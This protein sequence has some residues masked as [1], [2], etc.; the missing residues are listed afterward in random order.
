MRDKSK[1]VFKKGDLV[2]YTGNQTELFK[3]DMP[4]KVA[5][6]V[7]KSINYIDL[8]VYINP[9]RIVYVDSKDFISQKEWE[10]VSFDYISEEEYDNDN[11][12]KKKKNDFM[13]GD[14]VYYD[15]DPNDKIKRHIAFRLWAGRNNTFDV[16]TP[17]ENKNHGVDK[18]EW[19][20]LPA[21][22]VN[23]NFIHEEEYKKKYP[24]GSPK[25]SEHQQAAV[26]NYD[27]FIK[28]FK[29]GDTI[30]YVGDR[31]SRFKKDTP[32]KVQFYN[33][34]TKVLKIDGDIYPSDDFIKEEEYE[35]LKLLND[36]N[37]VESGGRKKKN[38]MEIKM[39]L[40]RDTKSGKLIWFRPYEI[41]DEWFRTKIKLD[42]PPGAYLRVDLKRERDQWE[43]LIYYHRNSKDKKADDNSLLIQNLV[44]SKIITA[45]AKR[46]DELIFMKDEED[47]DI[48][49]RNRET[50]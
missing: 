43:L 46:I 44:E 14:I 3:K 24:N 34:F 27:S 32:Y 16:F 18:G 41:N 6:C 23:D 25:E 11:N 38:E 37:K 21:S 29:V 35:K 28:G 9:N 50:E 8:R 47:L 48:R 12:K 45:L 39:D 42:N 26:K 22:F 4:Y 7:P 10:P 15:G 40:W 17:D 49:R 19:I 36:D 1:P 30:Y 31:I 2:Y 33:A 5:D 20:T 13:S